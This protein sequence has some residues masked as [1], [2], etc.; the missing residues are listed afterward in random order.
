MGKGK[1]IRENREQ[2]PLRMERGIFK[3]FLMYVMANTDDDSYWGLQKIILMTCG[4]IGKDGKLTKQYED[5]PFWEVKDGYI[6]PSEIMNA[7][8]DLARPKYQGIFI[9]CDNCGGQP[10]FRVNGSGWQQLACKCGKSTAFFADKE[11]AAGAWNK[12]N[13]SELE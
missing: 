8:D 12:S 13:G 9:P 4:L 5:S 7:V 2:K 1:R 3:L 10:S 11:D 6:V